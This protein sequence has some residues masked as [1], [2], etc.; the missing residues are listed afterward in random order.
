MQLDED[1]LEG[2]YHHA[3]QKGQVMGHWQNITQIKKLSQ[4]LKCGHLTPLYSVLPAPFPHPTRVPAQAARRT[5]S[6]TSL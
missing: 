5:G 6:L 3:A 1:T 2:I 4:T